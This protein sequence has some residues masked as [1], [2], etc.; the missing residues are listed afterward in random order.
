MEVNQIKD[1]VNATTKEVLGETALQIDDLSKVVELGDSVYNVKQMD[2]YVRTLIDQIGK[3]VFVNRPYKGSVPSVL[4]DGWEYG[5]VLEKITMDS[6]PEAQENDSWKLTNGTSYDPNVFNGPKVS[7][8]FFNTK[9]TF[10][11]PMS[12]ADRQVK[13]AFQSATQLN[14]FMSMIE[15]AISNSMTVKIDSLIS[16]TIANMIGQTLTAGGTNRCVNLLKEYNARFST[17]LKA[18]K[19]ITDADFIRWASFRMGLYTNRLAKISKLFNIG[20]KE[21]FTTSDRLHMVMLDEFAKAADSYLQSD[22][23]HETFTQLPKGELVTYWQGSGTGY[24]FMDTSAIKVKIANP[25]GGT[26]YTVEQTGILGVAFDSDALGVVC[27]NKRVTTQYNGRAEF[28]NNWYKFDAGYFNDLNENFIVFY[29][30]DDT[31]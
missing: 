29:V 16:G 17:T 18:E 9:S 23:Y 28:Y 2:N 25:S 6:L 15:G 12:F 26:E 31:E 4:M 30:S 8:K 21:R 13:S 11:I 22:T 24:D 20:G 1:L 3:I 14:A 10:E 7:A 27:E 19:C 5:A